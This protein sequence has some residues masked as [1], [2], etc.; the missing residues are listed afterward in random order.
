MQR[1]ENI[2]AKAADFVLNNSMNYI[3]ELG[4]L[5]IFEAPLF[6]FAN[7]KDELFG[8]L[9]EE[10]IIGSHH[11]E[12]EQWLPGAQT[13]ISYFLPFSYGVRKSNRTSNKIPST[14]WLYGRIE[15]QALNNALANYLVS[16]LSAV[17][18]KAICPALDSRF[19]V[20]NKRSNW[21]ERHVAFIA[22]LG[23]FNLS[24]SF[25]TQMGCA[26]RLGSVVTTIKYPYTK[27][28][29]KDKYEYCNFCGACIKRCPALA[30]S[31]DGKDHDLCSKYIDEI[32]LPRY[33][34]RY[35]CGKCQTGVPCENQIPK[36]KLN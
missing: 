21:S 6:A 13:V 2:A 8:K 27:R 19:T 30:I 23:T 9:K 32:I 31:K 20:I 7:P 28:K 14:E 29:Y 15:G 10:E 16:E 5:Q 17:G 33:K 35:G 24:K 12:P 22:G 34:P 3:E 36:N 25:I 11:M 4:K 26:G 1:I 18:G